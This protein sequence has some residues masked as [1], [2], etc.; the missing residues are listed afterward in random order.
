VQFA[1]NVLLFVIANAMVQANFRR[2]PLRQ[3]VAA[4][5][6]VARPAESSPVT[7]NA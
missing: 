1:V 4:P 2:R 6:P 5:K 7:E 3:P